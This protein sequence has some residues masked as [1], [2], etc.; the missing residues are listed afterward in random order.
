MYVNLKG[1]DPE[2]IVDPADYERV[3]HEIIDALLAYVD[4][5]TGRRPVCMALSKQDA[6]ILGLY[7]DGVGDVIYALYPW[8]GSQ[9]G[10][11]LPTAE[12]GVGSLKG[13]LTFTGPG[14]RQGC[15]L[16]RTVRLVDVVP[17]VCYAMDLPVPAETEGSVIYQ[18]F[19]DPDF[20][21]AEVRLLREE[22]ARM[23][24]ALA[25]TA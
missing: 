6:R 11:A 16:Q 24:T 8:F 19:K 3:Q 10:Q 1:R 14:F 22:L 17:T 5:E 2:G 21:S 4:P 20:R 7:G 18:A 25:G 23:E 15:R 9:H 13:L 12:W